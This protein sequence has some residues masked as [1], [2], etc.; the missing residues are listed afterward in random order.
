[1]VMLQ[2]KPFQYRMQDLSFWGDC[3][4]THISVASFLWDIGKECRPRSD[5]AESGV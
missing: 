3:E 4:L 2:K 1:M 5:A